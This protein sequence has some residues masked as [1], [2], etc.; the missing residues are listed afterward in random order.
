MT[1]YLKFPDEKTAIS[2]LNKFRIIDENNVEQWA[3]ASHEHALDIIGTIFK[4]TGEKILTE[5]SMLVDV[6]APQDGFH[7]NFIGELPKEAEKY[8]VYP[9]T[10]SR[11][12]F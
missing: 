1:I 4:A 2:V 3:L 10:P 8:I 5:D 12:F 7:V 11:V 6:T 9:S